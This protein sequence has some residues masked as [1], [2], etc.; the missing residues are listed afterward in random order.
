MKGTKVAPRYAKALLELAIDTNQVEAIQ[1]NMAEVLN[2]TQKSRDFK[3]LIASPIVRWDKKVSIF[4][5]VFSHFEEISM[6]FIEL[7]TK[8]RR[9]YLLPEIARAYQHQVNKHLGITPV[10]IISA[11]EM[12]KTTRTT[13]LQ[14]ISEHISGKLEVTEKVSPELIGG[15]IIQMD[16]KQIDASVSSQL[17]GLRQQLTQ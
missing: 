9:E 15:F 10:K 5:A 4:R 13:V 6:K 17:N 1:R 3:L 7:I 2:A 16:G 12:D 11:V 14:K 8:K